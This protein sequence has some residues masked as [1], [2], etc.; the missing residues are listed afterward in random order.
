MKLPIG[1]IN[2]VNVGILDSALKQFKDS[3]EI[4]SKMRFKRC[5]RILQLEQATNNLN[6][7]VKHDFWFLFMLLVDFMYICK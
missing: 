3:G 4:K 5:F 6:R 7:S 1:L 2:N